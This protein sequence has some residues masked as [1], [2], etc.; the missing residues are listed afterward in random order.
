MIHYSSPYSVDRDLGKAY[1]DAMQNISSE[2][3]WMCFTD[4]DSMFLTPNYGHQLDEIVKI[5]PTHGILTCL[6]NR[7]GNLDQCYNK[8]I[9][10]DP[11]IRNHKRIALKLQRENKIEVQDTI[12]VI[13]GMLML[14]K[15]S[16][17]TLI[18]GAPEGKGLLSIDN[19]I[20][21]RVL[22]EGMKIGIMQG[23]Y[24]FHFYRLD[25]GIHNKDHLILTDEQAEIHKQDPIRP[26]RKRSRFIGG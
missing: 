15:K 21:Q 19:H 23:V 6:T 18:H 16:T 17:W 25:T 12:H 13:S 26:K 4:A 24:I 14:I 7:V 11:D 8:H 9:N 2:D 10:D 5:Y 3:D 20:S 22:N 1:N